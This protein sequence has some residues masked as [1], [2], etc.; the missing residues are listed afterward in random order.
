MTTRLAVHLAYGATIEW[1]QDSEI[2]ES[3]K[4]AASDRI[5]GRYLKDA[6]RA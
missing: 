5:I 2:H 4:R 6:S 1:G 3:A